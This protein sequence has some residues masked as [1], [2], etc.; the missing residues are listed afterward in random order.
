MDGHER[1]DVL[2]HRKEFLD[3]LKELRDA[4]LPPPPARDERA[5]TPP[6]DAETRKQ[7]LPVF[8]DKS[9]FSI[10]EGQ[11][12]AWATGDEPVIQPKTKGAG[13]MVSDFIEEHGGF[14]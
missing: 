1:D 14:L 11:T 8:H 10:N 7:L 2:A 6:P 9:I 5:A 13:I 12:W 3:M 4:H